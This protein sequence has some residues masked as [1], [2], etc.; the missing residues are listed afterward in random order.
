MDNTK[1]PHSA[2]VAPAINVSWKT[3]V[4]SLKMG[5]ELNI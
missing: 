5:S 1:L 4:R 2:N 3:P